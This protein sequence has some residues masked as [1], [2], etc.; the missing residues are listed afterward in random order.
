MIIVLIVLLALAI[1]E[2]VAL[3]FIKMRPKSE[4]PNNKTQEMS[5]SVA[6]PTTEPSAPH[7][8]H[9]T[10]SLKEM[11]MKDFKNGSVA[12]PQSQTQAAGQKRFRRN[13]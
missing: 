4:K 6:G 7:P 12:V 8:E 1:L 2:V 5:V 9:K 3:C 13:K 11:V 10:M